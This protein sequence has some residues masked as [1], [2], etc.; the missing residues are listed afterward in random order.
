MCL[1]RALRNKPNEI[2]MDCIK[3]ISLIIKGVVLLLLLAGCSEDITTGTKVEPDTLAILGFNN[4]TLYYDMEIELK[5]GASGGDGVYRYRYIQNPPPE[6][7]ENDPDFKFNPL[8]LEVENLKKQL[9]ELKEE[10]E[11]IKNGTL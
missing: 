3:K 6:E 7:Q 9:L 8:E 10:I 1:T 11:Q 5:Y 2:K 4:D